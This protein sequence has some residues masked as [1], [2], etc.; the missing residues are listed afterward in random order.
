MGRFFSGCGTVTSPGRSGC[1][2][3]RWLPF[4][5]TQSQPSFNSRSII[6][7]LFLT[8]L[9]TLYTNIGIPASPIFRNRP[10]LGAGKGNRTRGNSEKKS[11][12]GVHLPFLLRLGCRGAGLF[13]VVCFSA[14]SILS[15]VRIDGE[16]LPDSIRAMVS[17]RIPASTASAC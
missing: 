16:C 10:C 6:S 1:L 5:R 14:R 8:Q 12:A 3:C 4:V 15:I 17:A 13:F 2:Y 7:R 11:D 9:Y